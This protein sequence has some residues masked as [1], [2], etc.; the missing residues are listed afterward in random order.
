MRAYREPDARADEPKPFAYTKRRSAPSIAVV[1]GTMLALALI[2]GGVAAA[3][4]DYWLL[5]Y[6]GI[7]LPLFYGLAIYFAGPSVWERHRRDIALER[8]LGRPAEPVRVVVAKAPD[9][10]EVEWADDAVGASKAETK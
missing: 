6:A 10:I 5:A 7:V 3:G 8:E 2:T 9:E 4:G 1:I